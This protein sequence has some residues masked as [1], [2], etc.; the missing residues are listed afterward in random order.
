MI[1]KFEQEYCWL[2]NF[3]T[4]PIIYEGK[5]YKSVEHA[6]QASKMRDEEWKEKIRQVSYAGEAKRI[7]RKGPMKSDWGSLN[8]SVMLELV[9]MKFEIPELRQKL[10]ETG[11]EPIEEGNFWHDNFWGNCLCKKCKEIK[12]RNFLGEILMDVRMDIRTEINA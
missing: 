6:Y 4:S 3:F 12:G 5:R 11:K 9:R 2:S 10:L 7:G 1:E 8:I